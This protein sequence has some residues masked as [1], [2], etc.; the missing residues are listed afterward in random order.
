MSLDKSIYLDVHQRPS[1]IPTI[2]ISLH[3]T[4]CI[5]ERDE[6]VIEGTNQ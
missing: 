2:S 3:T 6:L 4:T 1:D 5:H